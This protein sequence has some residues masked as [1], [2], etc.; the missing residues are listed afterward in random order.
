[1][2]GYA[3]AGAENL[4]IEVFIK[5][6]GTVCGYCTAERQELN[7]VPTRSVSGGCPHT[8]SKPILIYGRIS[9]MITNE[10]ELEKGMNSS[11]K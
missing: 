6:V 5:W 2:R 9:K 1:M 4:W 10:N 7:I 8:Q 11:E 3:V